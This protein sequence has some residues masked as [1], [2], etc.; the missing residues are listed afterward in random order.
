MD[1]NL[2]HFPLFEQI[3]QWSWRKPQEKNYTSWETVLIFSSFMIDHKSILNITHFFKVYYYSGS[4]SSS[5]TNWRCWNLL[6]WKMCLP[7]IFTL[8]HINREDWILGMSYTFLYKIIVYSMKTDSFSGEIYNNTR[9]ILYSSIT[10]VARYNIRKTELLSLLRCRVSERLSVMNLFA[11][12][13]RVQ[14]GYLERL[15][16][17]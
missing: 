2:L 14:R 1:E 16:C 3:L 17:L 11:I 5:P 12:R 10:E 13:L 15:L 7:I 9:E 4:T 8:V 6:V